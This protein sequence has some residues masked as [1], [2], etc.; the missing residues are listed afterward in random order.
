[1]AKLNINSQL[2]P[3]LN[4]IISVAMLFP[5]TDIRREQIWNLIIRDKDLS[6]QLVL[7]LKGN[8]TSMPSEIN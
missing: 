4:E 3:S 5:I 6:K 2:K 7:R 1:M 8:T